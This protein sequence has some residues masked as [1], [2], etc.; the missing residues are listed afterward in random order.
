MA[1]NPEDD[2]AFCARSRSWRG[3]VADKALKD[4]LDSGM[5]SH[6]PIHAITSPGH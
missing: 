5:N 1:S 4:A 3:E 6:P 2:S